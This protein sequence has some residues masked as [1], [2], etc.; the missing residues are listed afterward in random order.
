M[1]SLKSGLLTLVLI[2]VCVSPSNAQYSS[3]NTDP[4]KVL[5]R[6]HG[7][8]ERVVTINKSRWIPKKTI[9]KGVMDTK[10]ILNKK[11]QE[12]YVK[13]S[14]SESKE[15]NRYDEASKKYNKWIFSSDGST[16]FWYGDWDES[17]KTMT[18]NYLDFS[19]IGISG[20]IIEQFKTNPQ[21]E[22]TVI[23][24]DSKGNKLLDI[25]LTSRAIR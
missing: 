24:E 8:W 15:I 12:S 20:K 3:E 7:D 1:R 11:Y 21:I 10:F 5:S 4:I 17:R 25:E 9:K 23:M 2:I 18:W 22:T 19:G 13:D 14:D 16:S 6:W